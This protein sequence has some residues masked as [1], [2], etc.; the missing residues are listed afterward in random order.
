LR[1]MRPA[2]EKNKASDSIPPDRGTAPRRIHP[3]RANRSARSPAIMQI[4]G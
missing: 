2:A 4:P 1:A 3:A